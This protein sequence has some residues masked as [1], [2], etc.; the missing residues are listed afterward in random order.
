MIAEYKKQLQKVKTIILEY[1]VFR[2]DHFIE[3][4]EQKK[5]LN[6]DGLLLNPL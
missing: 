2:A 6:K 5:S 3:I 4:E 1:Y